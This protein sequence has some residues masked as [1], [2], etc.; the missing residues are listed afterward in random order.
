MLDTIIASIAGSR[1][2]FRNH[3]GKEFEIF[4]ENC[5]FTDDSVMTLAIAKA[6]IESKEDFED[7]SEKTIFYMKEIGRPYRDCGYMEECLED[8]FIRMRQ[9]HTE[10]MEMVQQC[11]LVRVVLLDKPLKRLKC[12]REKLPR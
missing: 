5:E 8:G 12:W 1:F 2:E 10:V 3:K 6:L 11:A 9:S 7:L 4:Y